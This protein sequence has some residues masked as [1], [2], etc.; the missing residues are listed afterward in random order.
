MKKIAAIVLVAS[1]G[2]FAQ[3][4][5][6]STSTA[7]SAAP[8]AAAA[9]AAPAR[10]AG[11]PIAEL[12]HT[13]E[14]LAAMV[15]TARPGDVSSPQAL[16]NACYD[17]ISGAK[18]APRDWDRFRSLF[19]PGAIL[20][21]T[22]KGKSGT[23]HVAVVGVEDYVLLATPQFAQDGFFETGLH[24]NLQQYGNMAV[25]FSSYASRKTPDAAPFTRGINSFQMVSDGARWWL[26]S[27]AWD[28]ERPDNPIPKDMEK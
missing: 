5:T 3:N 9:Q 25:D 28:E 23:M 14:Q 21:T 2:A 7:P 8:L 19:L 13:P 18:G 11:R 15:P 10:P 12:V 6:P 24:N 26:V 22:G 20:T 27:I 1:V 17:V 16:V 4:S